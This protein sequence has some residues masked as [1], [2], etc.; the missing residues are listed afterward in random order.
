MIRGAI[1]VNRRDQARGTDFFWKMK[2]R[3]VF[4]ILPLLVYSIGCDRV[5]DEYRSF[6]KMPLSDQHA[7]M[8]TLPLSPRIDF[9]LAGA[10]PQKGDYR[11]IYEANGGFASKVECPL[12][13]SWKPF[14]GGST[15]N[16]YTLDW[17]SS[18]GLC[19][20]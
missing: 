11:L 10:L 14:A 8:S 1:A 20:K 15:T 18:R 12:R 17:Y 4:M 2:H 9:Y 19:R 5:P 7:F 13:N 16:N 3:F 6:L